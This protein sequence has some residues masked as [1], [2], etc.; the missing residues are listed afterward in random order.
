[1]GRDRTWKERQQEQLVYARWL[2]ISAVAEGIR[3]GQ[4]PAIDRAISYLVE[5]PR[6]HGSGYEKERIWRRLA[7]ATL[8]KKQLARL[9]DAALA[10]LNRR[11]TREFRAMSHAMALVGAAAF[12]DDVKRAQGSTD[13]ATSR[14]ATILLAYEGGI[15]AGD[16]H[17]LAL[18]V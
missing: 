16:R 6:Y 7:Q 17:R 5:D 13:R 8:S 1:M 18:R 9:Q 14:R 15:T 12:W 11:M 10:H 4:E 2:D 3:Q